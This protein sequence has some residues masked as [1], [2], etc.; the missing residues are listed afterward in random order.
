MTI[1][2][3][4][5]PDLVEAG[6][7]LG[8]RLSE[9]EAADYLAAMAPLIEGYNVVDGMADE[10][11][12]V[13]HPR[14]PGYRP[15]G[16]DNPHNAWYWKTAIKGAAQGKLA[17]RKV[18]IKDNVCVAGVPMMN[19]A[20]VLEG[21]VPDID[22][23]LVAR[24]LDAGGEIAGKTACEYLCFSGGS[25]TNATGLPVH[26]PWKRGYTTGGS[27]S[28]S[29]AAVAA[30]DVPMA[31]GCDQAGSIRIPASMCGIVGLKPTHGLV[32]YSGVMPIE[33]TIDH[34]GPMTDTV[35]NNALLLEVIAGADGLDPRQ[36]GVPDDLSYTDALERGARGLTIGVL[37][38]GYG[39]PNSEPEVDEKVR[40]AVARFEALG[41]AMREI[42]IPE[43][44][45][46][47]AVWT[48]IGVEGTVD[49]MM[50][51]NGFGTNWKGLFVTSLIDR[52]ARWRE[53]ADELSDSLKYVILLGQYMASRYGGRHYGKAQNIARR[54]RVAY[55]R[56]LGE[57]DAI[58]MPTL[59]ITATPIPP[60][61]A[62]RS[63]VIQRAHEMFANTAVFD[64]T[65]HPALTVP[66][67]L[68]DGLPVGLMLVG[69]HFDEATLYRAAHAYERSVDWR[70]L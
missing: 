27:S 58:L 56:A 48:P 57:C 59:P 70:T 46:G 21:Y 10:V 5:V 29:G 64:V 44:L 61:D 52:Y 39:H 2:T 34:A 22:A 26:N 69:R 30:G 4:T 45:V 66:C 40:A 11:P 67:G 17:G 47:V 7:Q 14:L 49:F 3:P 12:P 37:K 28:G 62:P 33:M 68:S 31:I 53:R 60:P 65:G 13:R 1:R 32:P 18:A 25:H 19:G 8:L 38:E 6:A 43:H 55:D 23:T 36:I 63:L 9:A 20:S 16:D 54:L 50:H 15:V 24:I 51:G 41:A 35:A 42:S